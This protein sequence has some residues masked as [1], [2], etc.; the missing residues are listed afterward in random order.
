MKGRKCD[1]RNLGHFWLVVSSHDAYPWKL[2]WNCHWYQEWYPLP[3]RHTI[4][5]YVNWSEGGWMMMITIRPCTHP[6][7]SNWTYVGTT[8]G[9]F[10][11]SQTHYIRWW[12]RGIVDAGGFWASISRSEGSSG[13]VVVTFQGQTVDVTSLFFGH[14]RI[15]DHTF[16]HVAT[17]TILLGNW[18]CAWRRKEQGQVGQ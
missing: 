6:L 4:I 12:R 2:K 1:L 3:P 7:I 17:A 18:K 11:V 10:V 16:P 9:W 5:F 14:R 8:R 13:I 15:A